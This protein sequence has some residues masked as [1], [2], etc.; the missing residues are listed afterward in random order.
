MNRALNTRLY[1]LAVPSGAL[2]YE[3]FNLINSTRIDRYY[4]RFSGIK[5][6]RGPPANSNLPFN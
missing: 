2:L 1:V 6:V 5:L 4:R 3:Y